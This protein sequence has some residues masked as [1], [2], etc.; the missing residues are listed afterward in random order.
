M[1]G[2]GEHGLDFI[3][4]ALPQVLG[5]GGLGSDHSATSQLWDLD[6]VSSLCVSAFSSKQG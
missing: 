1:I 2:W 5:P 3:T 6:Q 4:V